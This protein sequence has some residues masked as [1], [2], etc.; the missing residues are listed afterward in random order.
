MLAN[1]STWAGLVVARWQ[2]KGTDSIF[3]SLLSD[4]VAA[5][6]SPARPTIN[7]SQFSGICPLIVRWE[8]NKMHEMHEQKQTF[9]DG[10]VS[11]AKFLFWAA[12]LNLAGPWSE[13]WLTKKVKNWN[14][15]RLTGGVFGSSEN[16]SEMCTECFIFHFVPFSTDACRSSINKQE[17]LSTFFF[18]FFFTILR[19]KRSH[20][21][22]TDES[23]IRHVSEA[24]WVDTLVWLEICVLCWVVGITKCEERITADS[25][26]SRN[27]Q[28]DLI[29]MC[30]CV[31]REQMCF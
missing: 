19:K 17:I 14:T 20:R 10:C 26:H 16:N 11:T 1:W 28:V 18:F 21:S 29:C 30:M 23:D 4:T 7:M 2:W 12:S 5:A 9:G 22:S 3:G 25:H 27:H 24:F 13:W 8:E 15:Q 31:N 6:Q